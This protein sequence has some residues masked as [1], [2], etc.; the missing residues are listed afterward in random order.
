MNEEYFLAKNLLERH[1]LWNPGQSESLKGNSRRSAG[2]L[3]GLAPERAQRSDELAE[4]VDRFLSDA[5][6][7]Y[8]LAVRNA[9]HIPVDIQGSMRDLAKRTEELKSELR[10][11]KELSSV[12]LKNRLIGLGVESRKQRLFALLVLAITKFSRRSW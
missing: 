8:S 7:T 2:R 12:D 4:E 1:G 11:Q 9:S 3:P 10:V 6:A 5:H